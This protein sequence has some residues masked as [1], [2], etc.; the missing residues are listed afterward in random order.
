[1]V[2]SGVDENINIM[3]SIIIENGK[4]IMHN[5]SGTHI[6]SI[7]IHKISIIEYDFGSI[8]LGFTHSYIQGIFNL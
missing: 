7:I 8:F 5:S 4:Q 1:M 2:R 3:I 6:K